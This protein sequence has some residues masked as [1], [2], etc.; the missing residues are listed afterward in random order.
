MTCP[1]PFDV[2]GREGRVSH[3][4]APLRV[5]SA[6]LL[7][8]L[9]A[10]LVCRAEAK[11]AP[12]MMTP[13]EYRAELQHLLAAAPRLDDRSEGAAVLA[14]LPPAWR[15]KAGQHEFVVSTDWLR[16]ELAA[17]RQKPTPEIRLRIERRLERLLADLDAYDAPPP[18][19]SNDR[20]TLSAILAGREFSPV[21]GP[22]WLDR[23]KQRIA[24]LL[25]RLVGRI[26]GSSSFPVIASTVVYVLVGLAVLLTALWV[27]RTLAGGKVQPVVPECVPISA[28]EWSVWLSEAR[29]AAAAGRWRDAVRLGYWAAISCLES[30]GVWPPDRARTPREYLRLLPPASEHRPTLSALTHIFEPVWYGSQA[31]GAATFAQ[32]VADLERLGA[33]SSVGA[34]RAVPLRDL[35]AD[36]EKPRWP[37]S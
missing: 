16:G 31:A 6:I 17:L 19:S 3:H 25:L 35:P 5:R 33:V 32:T 8:V 26:F 2:G 29:E 27:Y 7:L 1:A 34:R 4:R 14:A 13:A 36:Q 10:P 11:A 30:R 9:L 28:K 20:R 37:S 23:L 22:T 24:E 21:H 18:D 12:A 15:V